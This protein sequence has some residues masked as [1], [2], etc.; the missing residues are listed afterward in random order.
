MH[1]DDTGHA[2]MNR[3]AVAVGAVVGKRPGSRSITEDRNI[4]R[5][6]CG[7]E[8]DASD[9]LSRLARTT[10]ATAEQLPAGLLAP[11]LRAA[12]L[13][14]TV[15]V[16]L[17]SKWTISGCRRI[18]TRWTARGH[19]EGRHY[20]GL[21]RSFVARDSHHPAV[22]NECGTSGVNL[23]GTGGIVPHVK[24]DRSGFHDDQHGTRM[25]VPTG[26]PTGCYDYVRDCD[27]GVI[28]RFELDVITI[29]FGLNVKRA[30]VAASDQ[31]AGKSKGVREARLSDSRGAAATR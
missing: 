5:R 14:N 3:A 27:V 16:E 20:G 13:R 11:Q 4:W 1:L 31:C 8:R 6:S 19:E 12:G 24:R 21:N 28:V 23:W 22:L 10:K 9:R 7:G 18:N 29:G 30:E 25:I 15:E 17:E 26:M 2:R